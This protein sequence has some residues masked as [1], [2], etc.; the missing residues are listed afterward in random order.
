MTMYRVQVSLLPTPRCTT[1]K[2]ELLKPTRKS[3]SNLLDV[4]HR[5]WMEIRC[6]PPVEIFTPHP[7]PQAARPLSRIRML[8]ES[9][10]A[11][12]HPLF[13]PF[14]R[15]TL[16]LA[17]RFPPDLAKI[18]TSDHTIFLPPPSTFRHQLPMAIRERKTPLRIRDLHLLRNRTELSPLSQVCRHVLH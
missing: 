9:P 13:Q 6:C 18:L 4:R 10:M 17:T 5:Q 12:L 16:T 14:R 2:A 11:E 7:P 3:K 15:R 8:E 1:G